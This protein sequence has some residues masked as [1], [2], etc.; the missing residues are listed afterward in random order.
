MDVS[1]EN[2]LISFFDI[3]YQGF[4]DSMGQDVYVITEL[5]KRASINFLVSN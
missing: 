4:G 2:K 1:E 3:A 5:A